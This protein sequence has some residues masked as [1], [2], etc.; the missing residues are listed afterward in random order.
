MSELLQEI[1]SQG[2]AASPS[3]YGAALPT[4]EEVADR[5]V[6]FLLE[7]T[8]RNIS[9][10]ARILGISRTALYARLRRMGP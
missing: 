6:R 3:P 4:L 7:L 10:T 5:Y 2:P 1:L 9:Q 8:L